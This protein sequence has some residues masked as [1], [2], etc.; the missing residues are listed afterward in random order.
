MEDIGSVVSA[1]G[2]LIPVTRHSNT[3]QSASEDTIYIAPE[4]ISHLHPN[5]VPNPTFWI[6]Y[7]VDGSQIKINAPLPDGW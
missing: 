2:S 3:A 4:T 5:V 6:V 7:F 1:I